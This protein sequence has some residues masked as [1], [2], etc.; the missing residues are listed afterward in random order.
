MAAFI[1]SLA[2]F[3]CLLAILRWSLAEALHASGSIITYSRL[4]LL[5]LRPPPPGEPGCLLPDADSS[6]PVPQ[7]K[8]RK[9]GCRGSR[10]R[11]RRRGFKPVLPSVIMGNLRSLVNKADELSALLKFDRL[12]RQSSLLCFT[13]S[14]LTDLIPDSHVEMDDFTL[15][16][17]DRDPVRSGK[18]KGGGVCVYTNDRWCH[19]AHVSIKERICDPNIELLAVSCR[20]YHLPREI[21]HVIV[22]VVYIPP[23]ANTKLA[24]ETISRVTHD[25]QRV[26]PFALVIVN[27]DF[28]NCTLSATLPSF[29]QFVKCPTRGARTLDLFYTNV[30]KSYVVKPLP[31]LGKSDHNLLSVTSR[32][33]PVIQRQPIKSKTVRVWSEEACDKLQGSFECTDWSIFL[34]DDELD[35]DSKANRV[36][37]YINFCVDDAIPCKT[38]KIFPNDKPWMSREVKVAINQK[39]R[40][41]YSGDADL[42]KSAQKDLK[43]KIKQAKLKYKDRV[44]RQMSNTNTRGLWKGMKSITDWT[45]DSSSLGTGIDVDQANKFFARFDS[46]DFSAEHQSIL[47][48]LAQPSAEDSSPP[49]VIS[50]EEVRRELK[51]IKVNKGPGPDGV[52]PR[53][54]RVCADQ[55]CDVF[56]SLFSLSLSSCSIPTLWLK[57]CLVPIPKKNKVCSSL[58]DLRP[59]ALTCHIMKCFE[60]VVLGHLKSQVAPYLDPFQFAYRKRVGVDDALI[61]MMHKIYSHLESPASSVRIMFFDFSSAFNTIQ[62]HILANKL[63]QFKLHNATTTWCFKYLVPRPQFVRLDDSVSDVIWTK[64]GVPQGTVLAP[65]LFTLYTSDCRHSESSCH[66]QK[67]SDDTVLIGL[68]NKGDDR[69]YK[70]EIDLYTQWCDTRFLELNVD[71]TK[72]LTIN[73]SRKKV[74]VSPVTI[75]GQ[76]VEIVQSYKYLGVYL[77]SKLDWKEN[78]N[79]VLKKTQ[80]RLF[81]LRKLRSFDIS[82]SLLNVFYQGILA[83]VLFYAVLG[84]GGSITAMDKSRIN[85][86]IKKAG[87]IVG[88]PL[89]SLETIIAKRT[90]SKLNSILSFE[91]HPL[92]N[93]FHALRSSFS[94]RF[95]MPSCSTER[96]RKSFV[97]TAVKFLNE[98]Y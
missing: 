84:W 63:T 97:P 91:D 5:Q 24:A 44:E 9:R 33:S 11:T 74:S 36:T 59:I 51:C 62:P 95:R 76:V 2:C 49:I 98:H 87:S 77:D 37:A 43:A 23:S 12:Y 55:L 26:S 57:S 56:Y 18:S 16:R 94:N 70:K 13:E 21:S 68:I 93:I 46:L 38:V 42:I 72:E 53:T 65:F 78:S 88:L 17:M 58:S 81:H 14:W 4:E 69:A 8:Q 27:G 1:R 80:S 41:F 3:L 19:P 67:F 52:F 47:S 66:M 10:T 34:D 61:L 73:F 71:K 54:L 20:P 40:A 85:K 15:Q 60:R 39:R 48:S 82:R 31:P 79:S 90:R 32:Y 45:N 25:L 6:A 22:L 29:R 35:L 64:T 75:K 86:A 83:S 7:A 89:D 30:K 92:Y 28:N 50:L 96:Y